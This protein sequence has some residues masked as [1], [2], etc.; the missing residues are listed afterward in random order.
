MNYV[1][2]LEPR[3]VEDLSTLPPGVQRAILEA[4]RLIGANPTR[5]TRPAHPPYPAG[6]LYRTEFPFQGAT[7]LVDIVFRYGPDEQT[8]YIGRVFVDYA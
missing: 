5:G 6:M 3:A 2:E 1:V 8:L 7:C 4:M